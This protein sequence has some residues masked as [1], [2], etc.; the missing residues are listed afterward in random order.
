MFQ[1]QQAAKLGNF[2]YLDL[3]LVSRIEE[4]DYEMFLCE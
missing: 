4:R 1:L 3:V 2:I